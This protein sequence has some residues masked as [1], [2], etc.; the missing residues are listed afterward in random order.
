MFLFSVSCAKR[1]SNVYWLFQ[2]LKNRSAWSSYPG[3][4]DPWKGKGQQHPL[5]KPFCRRD[6][7][8]YRIVVDSQRPLRHCYYY[9][10]KVSEE[11]SLFDCI[12]FYRGITMFS[13]VISFYG[14]M[15]Y[16]NMSDII[17][18]PIIH[19]I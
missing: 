19:R 16:D 5:L 1:V 17:Y 3:H 13:C 7:R 14:A 8:R 12:S 15:R 10:R 2:Q 11:M 6:A 4:K 9:S 18:P